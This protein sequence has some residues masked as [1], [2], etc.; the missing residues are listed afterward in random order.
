MSQDEGA[1][2]LFGEVDGVE[3]IQKTPIFSSLG[4]EETQRLAEITRLERFAKGH[5]I[6]EQDSLGGTV[7]NFPRRTRM[8]TV[9]RLPSSG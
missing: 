1:L 7:A 2:D 3:L 8:E 6:V 5:L 9:G 4:F